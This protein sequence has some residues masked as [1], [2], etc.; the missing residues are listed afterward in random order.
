MATQARPSIKTNNEKTQLVEF[1]QK[2]SVVGVN[3]IST[4]NFYSPQNKGFRDMAHGEV[5]QVYNDR[6]SR[7]IAGIDRGHLNQN[8][9]NL[10]LQTANNTNTFMSP[11]GL[12]STINGP[13]SCKQSY[14]PIVD[15]DDLV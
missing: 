5:T 11:T 12:R 13:F 15:D 1:L 2:N 14:N 3:P 4:S 10:V 9:N 8:Q 7:S 6:T